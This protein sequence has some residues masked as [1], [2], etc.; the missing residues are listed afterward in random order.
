MKP[1]ILL[2]ASAALVTAQDT[3]PAAKI[4]PKA[5]AP[6][7]AAPPAAPTLKVGSTVTP[8]AIIKGDWIQGEAL[9]SWEPGKVY[10]LEC[11]ATWCG[12]C[13]AAI[14]HVNGLHKKYADKGLRVIGMNVWENKGKDPV[15]EFVKG[16]GDGMSYPVSYNEKGGA[17]ETEWLKPAGVRG[18]PHA[19]VIKDGKIVLMSHPMQITDE[20]IEAL[21]AGGAAQEKLLAELNEREA[22]QG[23]ISSLLGGFST[24]SRAKDVAAM[25]KIIED[26][27]AVDPKNEYLPSLNLQLQVA[28]GEWAEVESGLSKLDDSQRS[29][30]VAFT[31]ARGLPSDSAAPASLIKVLVTKLEPV[32]GPQSGPMGGQLLA[33]LNWSAG[34]KEAAIAAAKKA[35]EEAGSEV[36]KKR[37]ISPVPYQKYLEA[38]EKGTPPTDE[39][40]SG[41]VRD[42]IP[43]S[44]SAP[45]E[46]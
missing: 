24:A 25:A 27:K 29:L 7:E 38:L 14:P 28:K 22:N 41:W 26:V 9:K 15:V 5:P 33:K 39:E 23:K 19:F 13:I 36:A 42:S 43:K 6:A 46:G 18:I 44:P 40:F 10:M 31:I 11:W 21:L 2:F 8:D 32:L 20:L 12:P 30:M 3:I 34:N 37:G 16:K 4:V 35:L 1:L 45:A 17:F